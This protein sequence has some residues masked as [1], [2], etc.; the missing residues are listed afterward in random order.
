VGG[1]I[2]IHSQAM[3]GTLIEVVVPMPHEVRN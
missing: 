1:E 2:R 3:H